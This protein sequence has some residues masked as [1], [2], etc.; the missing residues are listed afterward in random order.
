MKA[1]IVLLLAGLTYAQNLAF[2]CSRIPETCKNMCYG[3]NC[4]NLPTRM[5]FDDPSAA[6]KKQRR[7]DAGCTKPNR[8]NGRTD[9]MTTCD[10]FPFASSQ[11]GGGNAVTRCVSQAECWSQGGSLSGF[12]RGLRNNQQ[13]R[14][15]ISFTN[16]G[17]IPWCVGPGYGGCTNDG[18]E[19]Q[20]GAPAR[21]RDL[22]GD[23][24]NITAPK[25]G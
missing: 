12:Y 6:T 22:S 3:V 21:R 18:E 25:A 19:Y 23:L 14:F 17:N 24:G 5:T 15:T 1:I 20:H 4:R 7:D 13:S 8:C 2:D 10:E 11:E 16:E 9:G